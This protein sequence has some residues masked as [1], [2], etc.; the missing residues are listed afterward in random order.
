MVNAKSRVKRLVFKPL[1][2]CICV[3]HGTIASAQPELVV[4]S[5]ATFF[6]GDL[7]G[8]LS[9]G[10]FNPSD[11]DLQSTRYMAGL[12][13]RLPIGNYV[14]FRGGAY[15]ARLSAN[16]KYTSNGPRHNRNLNFF[17]PVVGAD[18]L[19][20]I[21][22]LINK[23]KRPTFYV[24]GGMEYFYF[25][26]RTK[27]NGRTVRLQPLGTE[28]QNYIPGKQKYSLTSF[29]IPLGFGINF[30]NRSNSYWSFEISGRKTFTDYIDDVSTN[31][32]DKTKLMETGG[33]TAVDLSDRSL[34]QIPGFSDPGAIRG[35]SNHNDNFFFLSISYNV[36]A[37]FR[38]NY[39][40]RQKHGFERLTPGKHKCYEF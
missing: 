14:A 6:L 30:F 9:A 32:A 20:E 27:Y 24:F 1:L 36:M 21:R 8:K 15:Y 33:Q 29:A 12:G 17:S 3:L 11:L 19:L 5:G 22:G 13:L 35:H 39:S 16:D 25:D 23:Y 40:H 18:L 4:T 34:G 7:G 31:Y 38:H 28:G 26:P 37:D 2:I 10:S